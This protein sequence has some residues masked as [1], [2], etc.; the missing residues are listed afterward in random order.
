M[1]ASTANCGALYRGLSGVHTT[2]PREGD[3]TMAYMITAMRAVNQTF[4]TI[5]GRQGTGTAQWPLQIRRC[6]LPTV[7][8]L[9][10]ETKAH[11]NQSRQNSLR[12]DFLRQLCSPSW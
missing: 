11:P 3:G 5:V 8:G 10:S 1:S 6:P 9:R 7:P 2:K 4:P 12:A